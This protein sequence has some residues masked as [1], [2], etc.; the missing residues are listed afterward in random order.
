MRRMLQLALKRARA[1]TPIQSRIIQP[2]RLSNERSERLGLDTF[3]NDD[4]QD[5]EDDDNNS[6]RG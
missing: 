6:E 2:S 1:N 5:Y 3:R 4:A